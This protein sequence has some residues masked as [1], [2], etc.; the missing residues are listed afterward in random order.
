MTAEVSTATCDAK[1]E[2]I[3]QRLSAVETAVGRIWDRIDR[4]PTW[5]IFVLSGSW[6][7]AG[8]AVG[9]ILR[10]IQI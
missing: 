6:G 2:A 1:H 7:V 9:W 4:M 3:E 10:G 8:A 5:A